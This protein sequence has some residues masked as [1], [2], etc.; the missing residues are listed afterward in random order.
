MTLGLPIVDYELTDRTN[1]YV[2]TLS[3]VVGRT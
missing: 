3:A 1:R 2:G